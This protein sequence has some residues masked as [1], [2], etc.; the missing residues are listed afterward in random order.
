M[1]YYTQ[2]KLRILDPKINS[3]PPDL[4]RKFLAESDEASMALEEDGST[5]EECKWYDHEEDMI[6]LSKQYPNLVFELYGKGEDGEQWK[7]YFKD[8]KI[9]I[10]HGKITFDLYSPSQLQPYSEKE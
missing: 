7:K 8:G 6:G 3:Y 1:G 9:Q 5:N 10:A 2:Y 4:I